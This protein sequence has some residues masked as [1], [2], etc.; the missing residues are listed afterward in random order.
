MG[1]YEK[2]YKVNVWV[3]L[4]PSENTDEIIDNMTEDGACYVP[5]IASGFKDT[6]MDLKDRGWAHAFETDG[7]GSLVLSSQLLHI[8]MRDHLRNY[9]ESAVLTG[10][11]TRPAHYLDRV[12]KSDS[13]YERICNE[14]LAT[15]DPKIL[16]YALQIR[17]ICNSSTGNVQVFVSDSPLPREIVNSL[18]NCIIQYSADE[19]TDGSLEDV[20]EKLQDRVLEKLNQLNK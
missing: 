2:V 7:T 4:E 5:W 19:L 20:Y 11:S 13:D 3:S 10:E 1:F 15:Y 6:L 14:M 8:G 18:A 12:I 9:N 16:S 17:E